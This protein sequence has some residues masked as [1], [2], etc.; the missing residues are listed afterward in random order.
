MEV[1]DSLEKYEALLEA[2]KLE[3]PAKYA[4]KLANGEFDR[5]RKSLGWVPKEPKEKK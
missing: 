3:N 1:A 5:V 4:A 2:Y